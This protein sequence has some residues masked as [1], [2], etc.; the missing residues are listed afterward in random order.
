MCQNKKRTCGACSTCR[1]YC[2]FLIQYA[3][4]WLP[5]CCRHCVRSLKGSLR[6]NDG[7]GIDNAT[8]QWFDWLIKNNRAARAARFLVQFGDEAC[9]MTTWKCDILGSDRGQHLLSAV[10]LSFFPWKLFVPSK[11]KYTL[12]NMTNMSNRKTLKLTQITQSSILN[13]KFPYS[14]FAT[15]NEHFRSC[16]TRC[17]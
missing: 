10:S 16:H 12:Y 9:K 7:N 6:N 11:R 13:L 5:R 4:V 2:F 3:N 17:F 15:R 1:N 14:V 8:N